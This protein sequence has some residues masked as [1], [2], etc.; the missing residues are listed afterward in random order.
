LCQETNVLSVQID[1]VL[2]QGEE[3]KVRTVGGLNIAL[4]SEITPELAV[5]GLIR[6]LIRQT[7][8]IRKQAGLTIQDRVV[9]Y[10]KAEPAEVLITLQPYLTKVE[11]ET[12]SQLAPDGEWPAD[13]TAQGEFTSEAGTIRIA[14]VK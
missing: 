2:P 3:W 4:N 1:T 12:L 6:E 5:Q 7:N 13:C 8:S 14:M 10:L 11:A 9:L